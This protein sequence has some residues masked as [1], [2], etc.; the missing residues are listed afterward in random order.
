MCQQH[1][2][3]DVGAGDH[4]VLPGRARRHSRPR[5]D[6]LWLHIT[7]TVLGNIV[8]CMRTLH[9]IGMSRF[10]VGVSYSAC[11]H[12]H[13]GQIAIGQGF[14]VRG[15]HTLNDKKVK[16]FSFDQN[17]VSHAIAMIG[18]PGVSPSGFMT[19]EAWRP[20]VAAMCTARVR[21]EFQQSS[22]RADGLRY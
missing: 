12:P 7:V 10:G 8:Q 11:W 5:S 22:Q 17:A 14:T 20:R 4:V 16:R 9:D 13:T 6:T 3:C 18:M 19:P 15:A 1:L 21:E 2:P